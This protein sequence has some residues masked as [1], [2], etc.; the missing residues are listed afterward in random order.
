MA[1]ATVDTALPTFNP[2]FREP[3][4][5]SNY[6]EPYITGPKVYKR[7]AEEKGTDTQP[8]AKYA[9]YL[10]TWNPEERK[11]TLKPLGTDAKVIIR[12]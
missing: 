3:L 8:A 1:P 5:V 2:A 12:L 10:P 9:N 7:E 4:S 6:K 11:Y